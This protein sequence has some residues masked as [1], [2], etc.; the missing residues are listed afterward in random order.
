MSSPPSPIVVPPSGSFDGVDGAWSTFLLNIGDDGSGKAGQNF[1]A[2][3]S[4]SQAVTVLPLN[5]DWC[6]TSACAQSRGILPY[7][8]RQS[9]GYQPN[10]S[11]QHQTLGLFSLELPSRGAEPPGNGLYGLDSIGIGLAS[12]QSPV[13]VRQL[14]AGHSSKEPFMSSLGLSTALLDVGSGPIAPYLTNLNASG[15]IASLSYSYTAG[16]RYRT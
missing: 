12:P 13:V 10:S 1:K 14:V 6:N 16:A 3:A 15:A 8:G 11:F 7:N 9:Q 4:T 5:A 2:L